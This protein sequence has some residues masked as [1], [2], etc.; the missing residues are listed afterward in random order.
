MLTRALGADLDSPID[1]DLVEVEPDARLLLCSDGIWSVLDDEAIAAL[2]T[3]TEPAPDTA[4]RLVEAAVAA[5]GADDATALVLEVSGLDAVTHE[6][7]E[8]TVEITAPR[9]APVAAPDLTGR[10]G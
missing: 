3:A 9:S 6:L 4:A 8:D 2:L 7:D 5:G 1:L 10:L